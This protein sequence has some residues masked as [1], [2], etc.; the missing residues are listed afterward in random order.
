VRGEPNKKEPWRA[1]FD[2]Q[3]SMVLLD[4][5]YRAARARMRIYAGRTQHV[6]A[7]DVDDM[8]N[9]ALTDT[10][11]G[12]LKWNYQSKPLLRHLLDTVKYRVRD[13]A[14]R[15]WRET[16]RL[17]ILDEEHTDTS[18]GESMVSG[19]KLPRPDEAMC[20]RQI[21]D[22]LVAQIRTLI[23]NDREVVKLFEA[24][25]IKGA[26]ER[27]EIMKETGLSAGAYKNA[28]RRLDFILLQLP[29]ETREAVMAAF[30]N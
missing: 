23:G 19:A 3:A 8:V 10:L 4:R 5:V 7:A 16:A 12:T 18:L 14:R 13:D 11:D 27:A 22:E 2:A 28:R 9:G 25:C 17:D 1:A 21:A 26:F 30:T 29:I 24:I 15:R 20:V 6:N